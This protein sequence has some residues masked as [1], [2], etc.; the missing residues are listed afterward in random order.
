MQM[1]RKNE[2]IHKMINEY[3]EEEGIENTEDNYIYE[4]KK[5]DIIYQD[6]N[7]L[8]ENI[9]KTYFFVCAPQKLE[10][11]GL[12]GKVSDVT[13]RFYEAMACKSLII[14]FKPDTF[15]KLFPSDSMIEMKID[16]SDFKEK[17]NYYLTNPDKY[18]EIV[19][20]N[21]E[22]VMKMHRWENRLERIIEIVK[23]I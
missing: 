21:Y 12:T 3:M 1:G 22:Y 20:R 17:I 18:N 11:S 14:G 10:N 2:C 8:V 4:R 7:E 15:D 13:A 9:C 19:E 6:I 23:N 5:G 16:G